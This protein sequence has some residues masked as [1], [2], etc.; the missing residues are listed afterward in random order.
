MKSLFPDVKVI[1]VETNDANAM[2][3]SLQK[4][5]RVELKEVFSIFFLLYCFLIFCR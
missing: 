2:Y 3:L 1:G 5:E 4:G